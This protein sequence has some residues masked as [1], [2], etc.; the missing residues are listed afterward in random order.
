[1]SNLLFSGGS[2]TFIATPPTA[3]INNPR[4][5]LDLKGHGAV[6]SGGLLVNNGIIYDSTNSNPSLIV[7][8]CAVLKGAGGDAGVNIVTQNGGQ[9]RT[10]NSPGVATNLNLTFGPGAIS[11]IAFQVNDAGPSSRNPA[12][13]GVAGPAADVNNQVSGW[14]LNNVATKSGPVTGPGTF[15]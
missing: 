15:Q 14:S 12:A 2:R 5:Y 8:Y 11:N 7:D 1:S 10:G 6:I 13:P 3:D 9:F 4:A